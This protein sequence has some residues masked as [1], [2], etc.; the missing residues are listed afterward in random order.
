M[1]IQ[2]NA[3]ILV[4]TREVNGEYTESLSNSIHFAYSIGNSDFTALNQNYGILFATATI[5]QQNVIHEKG[6]KNPYIFRMEDGSFGILAVRVDKNGSEELE[7]KG[8]ILLWTSK[9]L[10]TFHSHGLIKLHHDLYVKEAVCRFNQKDHRYEIHWQDKAGNFYINKLQDLTQTDIVSVPEKAE[11]YMK[12]Q[13]KVSLENILPGNIISIED[14]IGNKILR[15]WRPLYNTAI[16]LPGSVSIASSS[17]LQTIKATAVYSDGSFADKQVQWEDEGID[18]STPGFYEVKGR[19]VSDT[20]PFPLAYG[21]ADPVI[22]TWNHKYYYLA[23]NDNVNDIGMFVREGDTIAELFHPGFKESMILN[24]DEEKDFIQTFW[25]PEFHRIGSDL[26]ILFAVGGKIWGP[27]CHMMKLKKGGDIMKPEDWG[28][29]VRVRRADHTFLAQD[30]ITLDM[31]YF[32]ANGTSCVVWSYR[33]DIGTPLDTGSMLYIATVDETEPTVLTSEP[34]LLTRPV[35]GWENIQGTINNEG[36]FALVTEDMVYITY[37]GGAAG[38]YTY[39]LGLLSIPCTGNFIDNKAWKK[40]STPVLSYYSIE[41]IYGP[42]HNS[43]FR[44]YNGNIMIMYH[45]EVMVA[46]EDTR[47][48]GMHRIHFNV[49]KEPV[50]HVAKERELNPLFAE[51]VLKVIVK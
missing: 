40:A 3:S 30:G 43:F 26:Y 20:Y 10:I 12:E 29:P 44:D 38:G 33:K 32:K 17:E 49:D 22:L 2:E 47:C 24:V 48:T 16:Q 50:F 36:P 15:K 13:P 14:E 45:G 41:G 21:Y 8:H 4:Y 34:V 39:A 35:L 1:N 6:V 46:K 28:T 42:G 25:A 7:S 31:T 18:F 51:V 23:T 19:V 9:D 5:D 11:P 27:Q 37:S